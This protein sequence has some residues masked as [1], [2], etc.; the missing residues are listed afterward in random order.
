MTYLNSAKLLTGVVTGCQFLMV[1]APF[2][3]SLISV[4]LTLS[5]MSQLR[6]VTL[7]SREY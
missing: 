7:K 5:W 4:V 3:E 2:L 1:L 6:V